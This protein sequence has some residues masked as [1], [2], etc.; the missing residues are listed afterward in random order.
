MTIK[1]SARRSTGMSIIHPHELARVRG[2]ARPC[3]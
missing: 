2:L 1:I 3:S